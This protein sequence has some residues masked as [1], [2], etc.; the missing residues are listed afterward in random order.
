MIYNSGSLCAICD[1]GSRNDTDSS[2][3]GP[4]KIVFTQN[5]EISRG[6]RRG[7]DWDKGWLAKM[8]EILNVVFPDISSIIQA[9]P[10]QKIQDNSVL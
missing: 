10:I 9:L 3:Q 6:L 8:E 2:G 7:A 1:P 5:M 4:L